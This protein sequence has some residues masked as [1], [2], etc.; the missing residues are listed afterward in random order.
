MCPLL[1]RWSREKLKI[2]QGSRK[3]KAARVRR[4]EMVL[5]RVS[6][7]PEFVV[8]WLLISHVCAH[9]GLCC[10]ALAAFCALANTNTS[11]ASG[12]PS[13]TRVFRG[14]LGGAIKEMAQ[15]RC[16]TLL[17]GSSTWQL[18]SATTPRPR[19]CVLRCTR[20]P[21]CPVACSSFAPLYHALSASA[22]ATDDWWRLNGAITTAISRGGA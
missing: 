10:V 14:G 15:I 8:L 6:R 17:G 9:G 4:R 3:Q 5:Q 19:F 16:D 20:C 18:V 7:F 2:Q 1:G 21:P 11:S 13:A 22:M 12:Y